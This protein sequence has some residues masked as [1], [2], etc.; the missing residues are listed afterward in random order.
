MPPNAFICTNCG[1]NAHTGEYLR[2][3][4]EQTPPAAT[5][6]G[7]R[8]AAAPSRAAGAIGSGAASLIKPALILLALA[9]VGW[10]GWSVWEFVRFDPAAQAKAKLARLGPGMSVAQVVA[11]AGRPQQAYAWADDESSKS[12]EA[13]PRQAFV[14]YQDNFMEFYGKEKLKY[15]FVFV[16]FFTAAAAHEVHFDERG[17][18]VAVAERPNLFRQ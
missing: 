7:E 18:S 5:S 16:Y 4:V 12:E 9:A 3:S 17:V 1:L 8:R 2:V 13:I 14:T 10:I 11:V 15:G 6:G